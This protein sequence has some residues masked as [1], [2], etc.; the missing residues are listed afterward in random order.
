MCVDICIYM[1][2]FVYIYIYIYIYT[3]IYIYIIT[4]TGSC[5]FNRVLNC[6]SKYN[7]NVKKL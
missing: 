2:I 3:Y 7:R 4:V 1:H 6:W 5:K